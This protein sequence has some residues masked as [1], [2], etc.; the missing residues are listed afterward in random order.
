MTAEIYYCTQYDFQDSKYLPL[1]PENRLEKYNRL[2]FKIDRKNSLGVYILLKNALKKRG[3][4]RFELDYTQSGKPFIK[5]S[6]VHFS[7][8]HCKNGFACAVSECEIGV[9]IQEFVMPK[10]TTVSR[11]LNSEEKQLVNADS[12]NFTRLWTLKESII[13]K[14]GEGIGC[15]KK[16]CF[17]TL[18]KDFYA[19][20]NHFVSFDGDGFVL[21]ACGEFKKINLIKINSAEL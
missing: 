10:A 2:R 15:Y 9:D 18:E 1:L 3:I 5:D 7:L 12:V 6:E 13:K 21:S 11:L 8:S 17:Q 20:D 19:F 14:N 16:Y 4:E